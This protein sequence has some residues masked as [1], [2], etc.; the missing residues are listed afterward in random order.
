MKRVFILSM[1]FYFSFSSL[2]AQEKWNLQQCVDYAVKNNIS[3]KQ[4]DVQAR[5]D[6]LTLQQSKLAL[7]PNASFQTNQGYRFGRS[8]DPTSNQFI[9][10]SMFFSNP[11]L[12]MDAEL[13]NWFRKKNTIESNKFL[14]AA[15]VAK[16]EKA[17]ND[18]ALNV[19][20]AYLAALLNKEQINVAEV[21]LAQSRDQVNNV[22]KQV[23][24]GALPELN[25]AE[26]QT[27]YATDSANV[28]TSKA[29]Y[30]IALIQLKALLNLDVAVPFDIE[31]P[32]VEMIPVEPLAELEPEMVYASALENLPQQK[33]NELN[34]K[35]AEKNVLVS[36]SALYPTIYAFGG[37]GSNYSSIQKSIIT[38]YTTAILPIGTVVIN[39]TSYPVESAWPQSVPSAFKKGTYFNQITNNFGQNIGIGLTVPIF[40]GGTARTNFNKAKLNVESQ[41]LLKEQDTR[42]LKQDIYLAHANAVTAIEKYNA[43]KIAAEA[44]DKAYMFARKRFDVGLLQPIDL[45]TNQNKL[46]T[47]RLNMLSAQ[48][49]YV[50]KMKLL[51]FY[52]GKGL[53]L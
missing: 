9:T 22:Q 30:T 38:G 15:S 19:A 51:E 43:S 26:V 37:V 41:Q 40:N 8:I 24:A 25:L 7:Y 10:N 2:C 36:K 29:N 20:N 50:F 32:P 42:T 45:I 53:K 33:I 17:R 47:A 18:I 49:D 34:I 28:L 44:A 35:S 27:Q 52:K 6:K 48:Y 23:A 14:A 11:N 46:F 16:L 39:G 13:F 1:L 21:Q 31:S 5:F 12:N 3:V 4:A